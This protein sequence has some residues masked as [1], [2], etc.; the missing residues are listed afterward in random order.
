MGNWTTPVPNVHSLTMKQA[1]QNA[2][3]NYVQFVYFIITHTKHSVLYLTARKKT[4][5]LF[6]SFHFKTD[7]AEKAV[8]LMTRDE[9]IASAKD[10]YARGYRNYVVGDFYVAVEELSRSCELYAEVG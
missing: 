7:M 8:D 9:K 2:H 6:I 5:N 3:R 10:F 1:H 4:A